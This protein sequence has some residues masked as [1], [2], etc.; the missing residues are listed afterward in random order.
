MRSTA[1]LPSSV[2][3][4]SG[5]GRASKQITWHD[6]NAC[7]IG[8]NTW[9]TVKEDKLGCLERDVLVSASL[10]H[11]YLGELADNFSVFGGAT[12]Q[13]GTNMRLLLAHWHSGT[14]LPA[15]QFAMLRNHRER[16][17][18]SSLIRFFR[19]Q[20]EIPGLPQLRRL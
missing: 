11:G 15:K 8:F 20:F 12:S 4:R 10:P 14:P 17:A 7:C 19:T 6:T 13:R 9:V 1:D 5:L 3:T 16:A 18:H 2:V